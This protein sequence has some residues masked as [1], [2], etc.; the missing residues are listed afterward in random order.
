MKKVSIL[1]LHLGFGGVEQAVSNLANML[2]KKYDVEIVSVYKLDNDCPFKLNSKVKIKY[3]SNYQP[4]KKEFKD[5]LKNINV[6][7]I[8]KEGIRAVKI[9][10]LRKSLMKKY[11]KNC[12]SDIIISSRILFHSLV[13]KYSKPGTIKIAQEHRH[14]NNHYGYVSSLVK[15]LNNI[16]YLMPVSKELTDNYSTILNNYNKHTKVIY[17]KHAL[18]SLPAKINHKNN[19]RLISVGRLSPEKGYLDLIEIFKL[20]YKKD[21]EYTLDIFG[22]G[23]ELNKI[24]E[25][26]SQ[27]HLEHAIILHGFQKKDVINKC[28]EDSGLYIMTSYEESFGLVLIEA[29]AYGIPCLAFSSA[30]G[31]HEI[32][33]GKNGYLIEDRSFNKMVDSIIDI[34]TNDAFAKKMSMEAIKTSKGHAFNLI[35]KEWLNFIDKI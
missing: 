34:T 24:K 11:I 6:L 1:V 28:L 30:Q 17:I 32:I 25:K 18:E 9:L 26:I 19:K 8:I 15:S 31:A 27:Y 5:A 22:D 21:N 13:G 33:N 10:F 20:L 14:H 4:N 12:N 2:V 7:K 35:Q 3:L 16:D 29:M 23:N